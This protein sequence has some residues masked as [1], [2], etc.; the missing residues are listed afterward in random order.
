MSGD[1]QDAAKQFLIKALKEAS[2]SLSDI[3]QEVT[4]H[5]GGG[6][7]G[8]KGVVAG[9]GAAAVLPVALRAA[10]K[11]LG[12]EGP[13][14]L[15]SG[16]GLQGLT[17]NLGE[18][19]G[20]GIG[21]KV[22]QKVDEAGGPSGILKD[23]LPFGGG[24]DDNGDQGKGGAPGVG[25]G[26]RMPVQQSVDIGLPV[27]TVY[28]QWTQFD[29]WPN[30]MHR[31]TRV[32][33]EDPCTVS[34][35]TKI[36]G[37]SKEFTAKIKTQRPDERIQWE[38]TQGLTHTGVVTF[39]EIG[40]RLTRVLL[41]MNVE[42]GGMLEKL[43]RGARYIKRA[44]RADLHRFKAFIETSEQETGAWR[45]VIED[46]EVTEDHDPSYDEGR[47][48]ADPEDLFES[49]DDDSGE[50]SDSEEDESDEDEDSEDEESEEEQDSEDEDED[51]GS[52]S[53]GRSRN[54]SSS[55]G[56]SRSG[57]SS[58]GRSGS[59]RAQATSS[60]RSSRTTGSG[61]SSQRSKSGG[62]SGS[63]SASKSSSSSKG[64]RSGTSKSS[65]SG[66]SKSSG[67]GA[68]RTQRR[69]S[70]GRSRSGRRSS[71]SSSRRQANH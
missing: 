64:S 43:A 48:Y 32:S 71:S 46:G 49:S 24:G 33:Q 58:R 25:K 18:R 37:K 51:E 63:G 4:S 68:S 29:L 55:R 5:D 69:Q 44:S 42:P 17:S 12:I 20:S 6:L 41:D 53:S 35:E 2:S 62:K 28:N 54:G 11:R 61:N 23:A 38:V 21:D 40:P 60:S 15:L 22:T 52:S 7:S 14:D 50:E 1:M 65:G 10:A 16:D 27:E 26:R 70:S 9:A 30:F 13:G 56:R 39:H 57:S 67:S 45:G 47:D 3:P 66:A 8:M 34:F 19:V 31:V 36:W 59:S